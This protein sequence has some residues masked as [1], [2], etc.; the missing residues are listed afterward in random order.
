MADF[1]KYK[2][3]SALR[4]YFT[5][6]ACARISSRK[7]NDKKWVKAIFQKNNA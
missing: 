4:Y 2:K 6:K 7:K 3:Q 1:F 5:A